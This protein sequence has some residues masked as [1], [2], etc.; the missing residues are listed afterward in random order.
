[1]NQIGI[2]STFSHFI[3]QCSSR[4]RP[5]KKKVK[6]KKKDKKAKSSKKKDKKK[7]KKSALAS[8][9]GFMTHDSFRVAKVTYFLCGWGCVDFCLWSHHH[10]QP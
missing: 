7:K 9:L 6:K 5:R 2:H 1:M 10:P 4:L 3:W 8:S